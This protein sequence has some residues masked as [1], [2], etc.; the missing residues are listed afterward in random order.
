MLLAAAEFDRPLFDTA[1]IHAHRAGAYAHRAGAYAHRAGAYAL[2]D[3]L[4]E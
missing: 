4:P 1:E 2:S 3:A